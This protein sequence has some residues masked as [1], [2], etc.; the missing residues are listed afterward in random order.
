MFLNIEHLDFARQHLLRAFGSC[1]LVSLVG[2]CVH[3]NL[4]G[5]NLFTEHNFAG[6]IGSRFWNDQV[7]HLRL[8]LGRPPCLLRS[9]SLFFHVFLEFA[10]SLAVLGVVGGTFTALPGKVKIQ[11]YFHIGVYLRTSRLNHLFE[12][13]IIILSVLCKILLIWD[14]F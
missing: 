2:A 6:P 7:A 9:L 12:L 3:Y 4:I 1:H 14:Q 8:L 13:G 10:F 11:I 5:R